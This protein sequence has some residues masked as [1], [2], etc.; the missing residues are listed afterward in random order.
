[1]ARSRTPHPGL[2]LLALVCLS[3]ADLLAQSSPD[4]STLTA[5]ELI[6]RGVST[7][8]AADFASARAAFDRFVTGFGDTP[9]GNAMMERVLPLLATSQ[10]HERRFGEALA[11]IDR[12]V[13]K[14]PNLKPDVAEEMMFW[15]AVCLMQAADSDAPSP[16]KPA[17]SST[18]EPSPTKSPARRKAREAASK[19]SPDARQPGV[20]PRRPG[21]VVPPN[22]SP[23]LDLARQAFLK[24]IAAYPHSVRREEAVLLAAACS[25]LAGRH[26]EVAD[27]LALQMERLGPVNR[28]RALV[29]RLH[30][31]IQAGR[32]DEGLALLTLEFPRATQNLQIVSL[33]VLALEL[34]SHFLANDEPRKAIACLQ[35]VWSQDRLLKHQERRS[36]EIE[37]QLAAARQQ[38]ADSYR[39]LTLEQML[40]KT[41][42]ELDNFRKIQSFDAS[43]RFRLARAFL[44]M[45]R[46]REA[47]LILEEMVDSLPPDPITEEAAINLIRCWMQVERWPRA[48]EA[49][50]A[51]EAR[52]PKS[53]RLAEVC[54][55]GAQS[56]QSGGQVAESIPRFARIATEQPASPFAARARFMEGFAHL[57]LDHPADALPVFDAVKQFDPK[58]EITELVAYWTGMAHSLAKDPATARDV[59]SAYLKRYPDGRFAG[60]ALYRRAYCA[61]AQRDYPT[62]ICELRAFLQEY[63]DH[64]RAD[65]A[66][67]LLGDALMATGEID[68]GVIALKSVTPAQPRL[69]EEA[70]FKVGR[71]FRLQEKPAALRAHMEAFIAGQPASTRVPEAIYWIGWTWRKEDQPDKAAETYW[72]AIRTHGPDPS[73]HAVEDLFLALPKLY[74][75]PERR[76]HLDAALRDLHETALA[77]NQPT[78]ALRALWM[79]ARLAEKTDPAASITL[80]LAAASFADVTRTN[81]VILADVAEAF[82]ATG[83]HTGAGHLFRELLRWN[84]NTVARDRAFAGLGQLAH[85]AGREQEALEWFDRFDRETSGSMLAGTVALARSKLLAERGRTDE[86]ATTLESMLG[87]RSV[88]RSEKARGLFDLGELRMKQGKPRLAVPYYQRIYVMY[89]RWP[90]L[91]AKAYLR[92]GE[93]F[94]KL[95]D[96]D[97][98]RKTYEELIAREDLAT[99]PETQTARDRLGRLAPPKEK[100]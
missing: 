75:G 64:P 51:F 55:L 65:E 30:S 37:Q 46:Y 36:A 24:F 61:H 89:G 78:L 81:P 49:A 27:D 50:L 19:P 69:L 23:S 48:A 96:T 79:R 76:T 43:L 83:N 59:L 41:R 9:E 45:Q 34:G 100:G 39:I 62:G 82:Q 28:G 15:R 67:I 53:T 91:V 71:A 86:A 63:G 38:T 29:L 72:S 7:F 85:S 26:A 35:R 40:A 88:P 6:N 92:S 95:E 42:R 1:M 90:D 20:T 57:L 52:F 80:R 93:A 99:T 12:L 33:H 87:S 10:L 97:A 8:N 21:R 44:E 13:A 70:W 18:P 32:H 3:T 94:E 31:L 2:A 58:P 54:F 25:A 68:K 5:E 47:A 66:R 56:L 84:P 22:A 74:P 14:F 16:P 98:A 73:K 60:E 77:S 17:P 11:T 4:L